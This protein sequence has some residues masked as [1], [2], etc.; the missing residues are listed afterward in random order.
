MD[1][2]NDSIGNRD[3]QWVWGVIIGAAIVVA[4]MGLWVIGKMMYWVM[5]V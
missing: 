5:N 1:R 3:R 4:A 2:D